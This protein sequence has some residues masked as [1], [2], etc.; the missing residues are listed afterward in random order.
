MT[1][2]NQTDPLPGFQISFPVLNL[3]YNLKSSISNLKSQGGNMSADR[4]AT[5][6]AR[7]QTVHN[8]F[9]G[10]LR[11]LPPDVAEHR[12]AE[13]GWSAAQIGWHVATTNE[14]IAG[15][16]DG[17]TPGAEAAPAGFVESFNGRALPAKVKTFPS[18][19]P[20]AV[21]SAE[22][23]LEKLRGS[24]H[25]LSKAIASLS[26]ER[27]GGHC[28]KLPFG[29]LSLYELADFTT[30]HVVRHAAQIE[31]TVART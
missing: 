19:E 3:Q 14:W 29:T 22:V 25:H 9:I 30:S 13:E 6:L 17:S 15:V 21:V 1:P 4:A 12:P 18:L 5:I 7:F 28:V 8:A 31:R 24:G 16:L 26:A 27:G 20:P 11:E 23:A 2:P 10:R